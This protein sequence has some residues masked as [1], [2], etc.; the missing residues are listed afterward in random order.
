MANICEANVVSPFVKT[1]ARREEEGRQ[2]CRSHIHNQCAADVLSL[3]V[4]TKL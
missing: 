3:F 2:G 1:N 4:I